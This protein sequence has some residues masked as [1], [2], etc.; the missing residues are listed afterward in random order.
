MINGVKPR[1]CNNCYVKEKQSNFSPRIQETIDW[2]KKFGEPD[3]N[4]PTLQFVD[5]RY[6]ATCNLIWLHTT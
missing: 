2:I 5:I 4:N 1:A 3:V 6:D